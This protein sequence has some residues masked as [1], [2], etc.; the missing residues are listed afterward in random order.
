V[1]GEAPFVKQPQGG[2]DREDGICGGKSGKG[3]NI[4]NV[5]K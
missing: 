2:W 4:Q 1:V 5:N 3:N